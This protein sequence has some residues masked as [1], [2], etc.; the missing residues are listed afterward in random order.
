[1]MIGLDLDDD[2]ADA[3]DQHGGP[4]QIGGDLTDAAREKARFSALP[5]RGVEVFEVGAIRGENRLRTEQD[6]AHICHVP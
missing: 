4:D 5:S 3:V 6:I 1:M 2:P